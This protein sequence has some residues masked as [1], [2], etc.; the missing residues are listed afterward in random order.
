MTAAQVPD[1]GRDPAGGPQEGIVGGVGSEGKPDCTPDLRIGA[2]EGTKNM[3]GLARPGRTRRPAGGEDAFRV[4]ANQEGLRDDPF[5][6]DVDAVRKTGLNR[7]EDAS[8][9]DL[10]QLIARRRST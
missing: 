2:A 5:E 4:E 3:G 8:T 6:G 9:G 10:S 1:D 7:G